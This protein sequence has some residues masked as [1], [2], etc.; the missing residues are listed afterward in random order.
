[1]YLDIEIK[2]TT[3]SISKFSDRIY[4]KAVREFSDQIEKLVINELRTND[5]PHLFSQLKPQRGGEEFD[6][7][8][9]LPKCDDT[10]VSSCKT[11]KGHGNVCVLD[12]N[13]RRGIQPRKKCGN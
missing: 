2:I 12:Q 6:I 13:P 8:I 11:C 9:P 5:N 10:K 3:P 4:N 1:M 7:Y